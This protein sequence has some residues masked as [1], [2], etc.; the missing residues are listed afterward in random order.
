LKLAFGKL[1][2]VEGREN[3]D[4]ELLERKIFTVQSE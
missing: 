3:A 4:A 2:A 1:F